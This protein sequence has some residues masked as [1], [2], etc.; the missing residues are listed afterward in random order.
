MPKNGMRHPFAELVPV[1][2]H[3]HTWYENRKG[4][5]GVAIVGDPR[6]AV[7]CW[8]KGMTWYSCRQYFPWTYDG[9]D[10]QRPWRAVPAPADDNREYET[11]F[12]LEIFKNRTWFTFR[13]VNGFWREL[14]HEPIYDSLAQAAAAA[15]ED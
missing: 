2:V 14:K 8:Q 9:F 7:S 5:A 3:N 13:D 4:Y 10:F 1:V 12:P 6:I 11:R 15:M